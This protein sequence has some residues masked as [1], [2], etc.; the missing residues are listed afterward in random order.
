MKDMKVNFN[1]VISAVIEI[2]DG[3]MCNRKKTVI[4]SNSKT[5]LSMRFT[6]HVTFNTWVVTDPYG[7]RDDVITRQNLD[8]ILSKYIPYIFTADTKKTVS[9]MWELTPVISWFSDVMKAAMGIALD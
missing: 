9:I 7:K 1:E 8:N 4:I 6:Y 2:E 5:N 3:T